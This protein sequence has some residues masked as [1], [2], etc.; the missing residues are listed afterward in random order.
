VRYRRIRSPRFLSPFTWHGVSR[1]RG[2]AILVLTAVLGALVAPGI[3]I[4]AP[5]DDQWYLDKMGVAE[6]QHTTRGAGVTI[7]MLMSGLAT[8]HPDLQGRVSP[9]VRFDVNGKALRGDPAKD[10]SGWNTAL[11]VFAV[12]NGT[13]LLG[14][15]PEATVMP[16]SYLG[17]GTDQS[18]AVRW[19]ADNGAKIIVVSR[20][21]GS[22]G[23]SPVADATLRYALAKDCVVIMPVSVAWAASKQDRRG[24]LVVGSV[25]RN[26]IRDIGDD[27][28]KFDLAAPAEQFTMIRADGKP[29][30]TSQYSTMFVQTDFAAAAMIAG[31]AALIRSKYADLNAASVINRLLA[32]ARDAG[33]PGH[34]DQYGYGTID[35]QSAVTAT[36]APV[37]TNPLGDPGPAETHPSAQRHSTNKRM[38]LVLIAAGVVVAAFVLT[39]SLIVIRRRRR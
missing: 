36:V 1:G 14:V 38:V 7:G 9:G 13:G 5:R 31:A 17:S 29:D 11:A 3:A 19:L 33:V 10:S 26:G 37:A 32:T 28:G 24:V 39:A 27:Y 22:W 23:E 4:A 21:S 2:I 8:D 12:G 6:A 18:T 34:D 16:A 35:V 25:D 30:R 15:A 20:L